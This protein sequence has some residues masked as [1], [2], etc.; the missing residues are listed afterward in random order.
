MK[1]RNLNGTSSNSCKCDSW[2]A[3]WG[4]FSKQTTKQCVVSG[5]TNVPEVGGHVQKVSLADQS[6]YIIPICK[7]CNRQHGEE[8]EITD[9]VNL[10]SAN[11]N[12]TCG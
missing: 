1:V 11:V 8:L 3:H 5:C 2:L 9:K 12:Y 10:V 6:W 7:S 4:N